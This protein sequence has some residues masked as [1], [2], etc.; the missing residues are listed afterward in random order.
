MLFCLVLCGIFFF[1]QKTA[2]EMRISDWSSDVCSSDLAHQA[3]EEG[4]EGADQRRAAPA[5]FALSRDAVVAVDRARDESR[6]GAAGSSR[7]AV[8]PRLF[9][10]LWRARKPL[11]PPPPLLPLRLAGRGAVGVAGDG[12]HRALTPCRRV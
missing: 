11:E 6:Q 9:P 2:Y 7:G 4:R 3:R 1:K 8:D 12:H 10:R 5:S